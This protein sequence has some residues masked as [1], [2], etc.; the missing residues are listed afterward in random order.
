LSI[1]RIGDRRRRLRWTL[2][3][4]HALVPSLAREPIGLLAGSPRLLRLQRGPN[5]RRSFPATS[6][7][8]RKDGPTGPPTASRWPCGLTTEK[9]DCELAGMDRIAT[10]MK[11]LAN[12]G[13]PRR[14]AGRFRH[15]RKMVLTFGMPEDSS[16]TLSGPGEAPTPTTSSK[17]ASPHQRPQRDSRSRSTV[18]HQRPHPIL[19]LFLLHRRIPASARR[20]QRPPFP[21][22]PVRP[23]SFFVFDWDFGH[24]ADTK[25]STEAK[26]PRRL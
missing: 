25:K 2:Q 18:R 26:T 9:A 3:A 1:E 23:T 20:P 12:H 7:P 4:E 22:P 24:D 6:C 14:K 15:T 21:N 16:T 19:R 13:L 11:L 5:S 8:F 17:L 10:G